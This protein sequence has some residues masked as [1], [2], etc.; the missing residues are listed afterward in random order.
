MNTVLLQYLLFFFSELI[1]KLLYL[2]VILLE[3]GL[4][5]FQ[6]QILFGLI[7]EG[8]SVVLFFL[9]FSEIFPVINNHSI[10]LLDL[11]VWL[12]FG[13][14]FESFLEVAS[15]P[16]HSFSLLCKELEL[17]LEIL[18]LP[19]SDIIQFLVILLFLIVQLLPLFSHGFGEL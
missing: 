8:V 9:T 18:S 16:I 12:I 10:N 15:I 5:F 4:F 7:I 19:H 17:F 3:P 13:Q 1:A 11:Y 2:F 6:S 14:F